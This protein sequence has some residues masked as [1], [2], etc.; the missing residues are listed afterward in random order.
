MVNDLLEDLQKDG[1]Q[2]YGY[3]DDIAILVGAKLLSTVRDLLTN[4]LKI[5]QKWCETIGLTVNPL[6]T[7]LRN[8]NLN[9]KSI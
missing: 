8:I 7:S 4:V 5:I 6:K 1:F 2:V 3:A 9:Q